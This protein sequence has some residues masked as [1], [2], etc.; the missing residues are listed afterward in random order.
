[1]NSIN[2]DPEWTEELVDRCCFGTCHNRRTRR[3]ENDQTSQDRDNIAPSYQRC[4]MKY[5]PKN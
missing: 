5:D 2:V 1:M 3:C 4:S